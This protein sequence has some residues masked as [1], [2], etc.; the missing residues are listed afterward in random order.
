MDFGINCIVREPL[1]V[2]HGRESVLMKKF[3]HVQHTS[4]KNFSLNFI[5]WPYNGELKS[6]ASL[7]KLECL[8]PARADK[9]SQLKIVFKK[10]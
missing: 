8:W 5:Y 6:S 2:A 7:Q 10:F 9:S 4:I 3:T 1:S